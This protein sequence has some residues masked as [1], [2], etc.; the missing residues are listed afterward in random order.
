MGIWTIRC[1]ASIRSDHIQRLDLADP[2]KMIFKHLKLSQIYN[3][4]K[5]VAKSIANFHSI[6]V[7]VY[8]CFQWK[9]HLQL[10][11]VTM[12]ASNLKV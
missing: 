9:L 10:L 8:A 7:H 5:S 12:I 4:A 3:L 2:L 11:T 6:T 1:S